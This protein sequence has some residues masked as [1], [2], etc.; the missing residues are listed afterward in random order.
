MRGG[1]GRRRLCGGVV[2]RFSLSGVVEISLL[3]IYIILL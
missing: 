3:I 1:L 2:V